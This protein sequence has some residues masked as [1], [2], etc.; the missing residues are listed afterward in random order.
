MLRTK[1]KKSKKKY[2]LAARLVYQHNIISKYLDEDEFIFEVVLWLQIY[3]N[4]LLTFPN[5]LWKQFDIYIYI[6]THNLDNMYK[7][8][9][10]CMPLSQ[11]RL[12]IS[13]SNGN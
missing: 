1:R 8:M 13:Y 2:K 7:R 5:P 6:H 9:S 4:C 3:N 11:R 10:Q 12:F